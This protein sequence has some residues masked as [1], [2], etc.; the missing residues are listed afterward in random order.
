MLDRRWEE[1]T[2]GKVQTQDGFE[3]LAKLRAKYGI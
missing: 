2:S 1:I 3:V